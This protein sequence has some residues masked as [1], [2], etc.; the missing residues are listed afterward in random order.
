MFFCSSW[1]LDVAFLDLT[2][3]I[4]TANKENITWKISTQ[5]HK[6][7]KYRERCLYSL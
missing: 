3:Y 4:T 1:I 2:M 7:L 5:P 6:D